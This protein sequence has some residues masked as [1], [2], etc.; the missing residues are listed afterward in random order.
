MGICARTRQTKEE[1]EESENRNGAL[2][3]ASRH[4]A[5]GIWFGHLGE[6]PTDLRREFRVEKVVVGVREAEGSSQ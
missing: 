2:P 3:N 6:G 4:A 5:L 1:N